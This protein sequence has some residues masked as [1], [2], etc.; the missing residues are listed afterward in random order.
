MRRPN[1]PAD[2][3]DPYRLAAQVQV[4][5][6]MVMVAAKAGIDAA[7]ERE[8]QRIAFLVYLHHP[9]NNKNKNS[10]VIYYSDRALKA[11]SYPNLCCYST[12]RG[13]FRE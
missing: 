2:G 8:A 9:D 7:L 4:I 10:T 11:V 13:N 3:L 6:V 12:F 1:G 5:R